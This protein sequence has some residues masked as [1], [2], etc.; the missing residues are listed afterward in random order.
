MR[1]AMNS[2][3]IF[4]TNNHI[5]LEGTIISTYNKEGQTYHDIQ[6][7]NYRVLHVPHS[8]VVYWV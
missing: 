5:R 2:K 7:S 3:V 1:A 4:F 8:N 6:V